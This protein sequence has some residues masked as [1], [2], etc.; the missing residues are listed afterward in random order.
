MEIS[1]TLFN[2]PVGKVPGTQMESWQDVVTSLFLVEIFIIPTPSP[3]PEEDHGKA[4]GQIMIAYN[5]AKI[6]ADEVIK[7]LEAC[8]K[9]YGGKSVLFLPNGESEIKF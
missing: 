4:E 1:L 6:T 7:T 5:D 3:D 9:D 8:G 2:P